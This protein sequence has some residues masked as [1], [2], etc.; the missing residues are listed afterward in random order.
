A[1]AVCTLGDN[2]L[3]ERVHGK[4]KEHIAI[5]G[6]CETENIGV[7][8][9]VKNLIA[10][11][12]VRHL[13]LCGRESGREM[14]GHLSGQALLALHERGISGDG[15]IIGAK[16]RRP[17][18]KNL[19]SQQIEQFQSQIDILD[20]M[21]A[22]TVQEITNAINVC[23]TKRKNRFTKKPVE[24]DSKKPIVAKT[25][26]RFRLDQKGFFVILPNQEENKIY[27]EHYK[28]SGELLHIIVGTDAA[29]IC[30]T[31]IQHGYISQLDHVAY[32]SK[33]LTRAEY[34][35]KYDFPYRQDKALGN[36]SKNGLD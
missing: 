32:L 28:N 13:I 33:E 4:L 3:P 21:G 26:K 14:M 19:S 10:N 7:E 15:R 31:I 8:K 25:P 35:L 36:V 27:V 2:D 20:L 11:A 30:N 22:N 1:V 16:G 18:L 34:S 17:I 9:V 24:I 23:L 5:V 6:Y 29:S 12:H